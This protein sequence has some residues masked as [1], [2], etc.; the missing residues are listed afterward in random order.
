MAYP[1][2]LRRKSKNSFSVGGLTIWLLTRIGLPLAVIYGLLWWRADMIIEKQIDKIRVAAD[3][4]R[5]RTV[6]SFNGD[7][8]IK[9]LIIKPLPSSDTPAI[10]FK[11]KRVVAH[12]PGLWWLVRSSL[13]GVPKEI[14]SRFGFSIE[15]GELEGSDADIKKLIASGYGRNS[16]NVFFPFDLAGCTHDTSLEMIK[17]MGMDKTTMSMDATMTHPNLN[18]LQL[19]IQVDNSTQAK[20]EGEFNIVLGMGK[21]PS[22]QMTTASLRDIKFI[23]IDQGYVAKRNTYCAK[24]LHMEPD[25]FVER[26]IEAVRQW[27]AKEKGFLPGVAMTQAYAGFAKKGGQL[28][29]KG[30]SLSGVPLM[31]MQ[32]VGLQ[33]INLYLDTTV[34]HN[35]EFAAP[36]VLLP[37]ESNQSITMHNDLIVNP[38]APIT[39][40]SVP[41]TTLVSP[42]QTIAYDTLENYIGAQVEVA[43]HHHTSHRG[44]VQG[45]SPMG[46]SLQLIAHEGG[47]KLSVPKASIATIVLIELASPSTDTSSLPHAQTQ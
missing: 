18:D 7:V 27:F 43:S 37:V 16:G 35:G 40:T 36:F 5:G 47:Y 30:K 4:H 11:A 19:R 2:N 42:G 28:V 26:H 44:L 21:D 10:S 34:T 45:V 8:G 32:G 12:T 41:A 24:R 22:L 6:L 17:A 25:Q 23:F 38:I 33:N 29:I 31:R 15:H 9:N 39:N 13:F 20:I 1:Y 46:L 14:P 3:I